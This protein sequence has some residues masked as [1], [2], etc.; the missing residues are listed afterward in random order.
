M[1]PSSYRVNPCAVTTKWKANNFSLP[2]G[3]A[4][5][6]HTSKNAWVPSCLKA[7]DTNNYQPLSEEDLQIEVNNYL[8]VIRIT[9]VT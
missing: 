2:K 8:I 7:K 4:I 9:Y 1:T 6:L 3:D 5:K